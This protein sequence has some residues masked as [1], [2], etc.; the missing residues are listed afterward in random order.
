MELDRGWGMVYQMDGDPDLT[1]DENI[2]IRERAQ[3]YIIET[4]RF[5]H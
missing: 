4:E 2:T 5:S 1:T 3:N